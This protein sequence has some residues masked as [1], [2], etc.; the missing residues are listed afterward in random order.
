M[1][2]VIVKKFRSSLREV[3]LRLL[4][5]I[6]CTAPTLQGTRPY[7]SVLYFV[8]SRSWSEDVDHQPLSDVCS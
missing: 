5:V 7:E 4:N 3:L 6:V 2:D 1:R 8:G